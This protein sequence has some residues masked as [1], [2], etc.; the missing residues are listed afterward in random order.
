MRG[1]IDLCSADISCVAVIASFAFILII[2]Q[3]LVLAFYFKNK[4]DELLGNCEAIKN[5]SLLFSQP[6]VWN[7]ITK[8]GTVATIFLLPKTMLK[9]GFIDPVQVKAFPPT[10]KY[11][12]L[13]H[14]FMTLSVFF[15]LGM[16][17]LRSYLC[18]VWRFS[19]P[20]VAMPSRTRL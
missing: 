7:G 1:V 14:F 19:R 13:I 15:V 11:I 5:P 9:Y 12:I 2:V 20:Q 6:G 16:L 3:T 4:I 18:G 10:F 8:L 17:R